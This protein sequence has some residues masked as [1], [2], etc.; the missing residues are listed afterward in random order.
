MWSVSDVSSA[1]VC[2]SSFSLSL[3]PPPQDNC[4][5]VLLV[6]GADK[7]VKNYNSQSPFQVESDSKKKKTHLHYC[8]HVNDYS[9]LVSAF[10]VGNNIFSSSTFFSAH[11]LPWQQCAK[12]SRSAANRDC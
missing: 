5:R 9:R 2:F 4:A 11:L 6:R 8:L 1:W 12:W 10:I 3:L 7:E